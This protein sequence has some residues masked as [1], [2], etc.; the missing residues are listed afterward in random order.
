MNMNMTFDEFK[1]AVVNR[2]LDYLPVSF[3]DAE[4]SLNV[5]D[6][7]NNIRLTG[8]TIRKVDSRMAPTIYLEEFYSQLEAGDNMGTVLKRIAEIRIAQ[9][10]KNIDLNE[11][12]DFTKCKDKIMPRLYGY[13]MN[14]EMIEHRAYTRVGDFVV[15]Y[16][17]DLGETGN[18]RI[19]LP[20]EKSLLEQ[21]NIKGEELHRIALEN[22]HYLQLGKFQS[23]A[24]VLKGIIYQDIDEDI[25]DGL[26]EELFAP[27]DGIMYVITNG[28]N[29]HGAAMI[30]D[31]EFM[32]DIAEKLG[33]SFIVLPSS[34]HEVIV[35][36]DNDSVEL[37]YMQAM[38]YEINRA[39]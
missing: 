24:E 22:Q 32:D 15:L 30:L 29:L 21:W 28:N 33:G 1:E 31:K 39:Q 10:E 23:M 8:L 12:L 17:V 36:S 18:G 4:I 7:P 11:L 9:D 27:S 26:L 5:V 16:V 6:K 34:I 38:V 19:S 25:P 20:V 13:D 14:A 2:V 35:V 3:K 37:D